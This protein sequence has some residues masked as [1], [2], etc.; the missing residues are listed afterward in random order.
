[1]LV[2][3]I[4]L[5]T[6][7][8]LKFSIKRWG[9][10]LPNWMNKHFCQYEILDIHVLK[11]PNEKAKNWENAESYSFLDC[12]TCSMQWSLTYRYLHDEV[13]GHSPSGSRQT[14]SAA[15]RPVPG[16]R[17]PPR[18][19]RA[20]P[21]RETRDV[22]YHDWVHVHVRADIWGHESTFPQETEEN[23]KPDI[24]LLSFTTRMMQII[25]FI[26]ITIFIE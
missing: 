9:K 4:I 13:K 2:L 6:N 1:M 3:Q 15:P 10:H 11:Q 18:S 25:F 24:S 5:N 16:H 20:E 12:N 23:I 7:L 19:L 17:R 21:A 14:S 26:F 8:K 22:H